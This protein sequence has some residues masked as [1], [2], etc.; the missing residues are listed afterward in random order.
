MKCRLHHA[1]LLQVQRRLAGNEPFSHDELEPLRANALHEIAGSRNEQFFDERRVVEKKDM[2]RPSAP[3]RNG[4][5]TLR[6]LGEE[7][8]DAC[9]VAPARAKKIDAA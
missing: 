5:V 9:E 3:M 4:P 8:R 1:P 6:R 2:T 7:L